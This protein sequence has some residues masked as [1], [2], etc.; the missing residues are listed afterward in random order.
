MS[1]RD[2]FARRI[3]RRAETPLVGNT[4]TTRSR[5]RRSNRDAMALA[6]V[7]HIHEEARRSYGS[8]RMSQALRLLGH[9]VGLVELDR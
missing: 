6:A 2:F 9:D 5:Q 8:R 7:R 1:R 3:F 4:R